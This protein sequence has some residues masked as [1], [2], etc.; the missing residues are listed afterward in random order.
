[1][2]N[3][4]KILV[5]SKYDDNG[6]SS[7]VRILQNI[8]FLEKL[9]FNFEVFPLL[10]NEYIKK[11]Y[12]NEKISKIY[13]VRTYFN[14][15][16]VLLQ[17]KKYRIIWLEKECFP[18]LPALIELFLLRNI[19][20]VVEYDDAIFHNY[21]TNSNIFIRKFLAKKI[22]KVM[23]HSE[24]VLAG[25]QYIADRAKL[26]GAE[27]I[28]IVPSTID[29]T[30]YIVQEKNNYLDS[31]VIGWIG[32][33]KTMHFLDI[34]TRA[35]RRFAKD[36]NVTLLLIGVDKFSLD[37]VNVVCK[38]WSLD[39]EVQLLGDIDVGIMPLFD[40]F[41]E[42]GKCGYK[43]IQYMGCGKP[44]IASPVGVNKEIVD[45]GINGYLAHDENEWGRYLQNLYDD[46]LLRMSF[47]KNAR[48]KVE[49]CYSVQAI[50]PILADVLK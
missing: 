30:K 49:R 24:C 4:K 16:K 34:V 44:V 17:A 10:N 25:N 6:A 9:G 29:L 18:Y 45:N 20:Y 3:K 14:R 38:K 48:E 13:L 41:W 26:A 1:M 32:T 37:N 47:G 12:G 15:I 33:P 5:L 7:R 2:I 27:Q 22:D 36:K 11:I 8:P 19:P 50:I 42:K 31:F 35:I 40:G 23:R 46:A 39:T 21:D 43:L 28:K